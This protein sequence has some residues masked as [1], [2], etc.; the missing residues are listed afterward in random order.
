MK[1]SEYKKPL[2]A[3]D[4]RRE[5][6]RKRLTAEYEKEREAMRRYQKATEKQVQ[7]LYEIINES[8]ED[9]TREQ[10]DWLDEYAIKH[11]IEIPINYAVRYDFG[12]VFGSEEAERLTPIF[13]KYILKEEHAADMVRAIMNCQVNGIT[14]K[15]KRNLALF[16]DL[17]RECGKV[18][19][20]WKSVIEKQ[21]LFAGRSGVLT[22]KK[23]AKALQEAK[24]R[25]SLMNNPN[26]DTKSERITKKMLA[27]MREVIN[28]IE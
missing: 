14:V 19:E 7:H 4:R 21:K 3:E 6:N 22:A 5:R 15:N 25:V 1:R 11:G 2:D 17:L 10:K 18:C 27:D 12:Q 20:E 8:P 24:E 9:Y 23:V 28:T 16:F 26:G 13:N